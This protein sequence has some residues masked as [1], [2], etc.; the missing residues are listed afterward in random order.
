MKKQKR[1][2][3]RCAFGQAFCLTACGLGLLIGLLWADGSTRAVAG[4]SEPAMEAFLAAAQ[5]RG[6]CLREEQRWE[7]WLP[8]SFL[9]WEKGGQAM[10]EWW[11]AIWQKTVP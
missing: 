10:G 7:E 5:E 11:G 4:A 3:K 2:S 9:L 6:A 8:A 1:V